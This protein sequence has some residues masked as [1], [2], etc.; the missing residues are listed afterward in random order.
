MVNKADPA[1]HLYGAIIQDIYTLALY[2]WS[3]SLNH[4][5]HE[6]NQ[7]ADLLAKH[8]MSEKQDRHSL[9]L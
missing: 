7:Y 3:Y 9:D 5:L 1:C 6:D 4:V 2:V 8:G